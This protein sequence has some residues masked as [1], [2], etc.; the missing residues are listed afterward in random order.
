MECTKPW[1]SLEQQVEQLASGGVEVGD[2]DRAAALL[3]AVGCY[4]LTGYLYPFRKSES[5]LSGDGRTRMRVFSGYRPGAAL[6]H[7]QSIIDLDRH[8]ACS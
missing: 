1:L 4:R 3:Q 7:A 8:C 2:R 5:Y 6:H